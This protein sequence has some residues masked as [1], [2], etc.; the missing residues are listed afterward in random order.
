MLKIGNLKLSLPF[1]LAPMSG[2]TDLPF[3]LI[4]R[5][6]GCELAFVEM[7][8]VRSLSYKSKRTER[9]LSADKKDRP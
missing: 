1:I 6:F 2:V 5:K 9:M 7:I 4:N 8:N 3:R